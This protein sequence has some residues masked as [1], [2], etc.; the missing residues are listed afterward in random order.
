[1]RFPKLSEFRQL[2]TSSHERNS[3]YD[4]ACSSG[5]APCCS[6]LNAPVDELVEMILT[7]TGGGR[8]CDQHTWDEGIMDGYQEY[9]FDFHDR[10]LEN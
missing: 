9:I 7:W 10:L 1:M 4:R 8:T 5:F 6:G 3:L 2:I